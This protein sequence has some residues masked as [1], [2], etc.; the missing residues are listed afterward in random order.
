[1]QRGTRRILIEVLEGILR[2]LHPLMPFITEEIWEQVAERAGLEGD[3]MALS[4]GR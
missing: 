1:M 2:L 4:R 3:T